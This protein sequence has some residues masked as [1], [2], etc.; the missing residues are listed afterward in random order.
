M[1][2]SIIDGITIAMITWHQNGTTKYTHIVLPFLVI[3]KITSFELFSSDKPFEDY[4][5]INILIQFVHTFA[6]YASMQ[7]WSKGN[8]EKK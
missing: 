3:S 5:R 8:Y 4:N 6:I 2:F 1:H 7:L